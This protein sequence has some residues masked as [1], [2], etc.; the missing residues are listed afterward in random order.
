MKK[1]KKMAKRPKRMIYDKT[2]VQF[3]QDDVF[4]SLYIL[5]CPFHGFNFMVFAHRFKIR[6]NT[7]AAGNDL[8]HF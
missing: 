5:S 6:N 8:F 4:T 7:G 2:V 1:G 3:F